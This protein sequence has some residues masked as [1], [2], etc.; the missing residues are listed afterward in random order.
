MQSTHHQQTCNIFK[1]SAEERVVALI[2]SNLKLKGSDNVCTQRFTSRPS[3][4]PRAWTHDGCPQLFNRSGT[5]SKTY[6]EARGVKRDAA[7]KQHVFTQL[8]LH[9]QK[10]QGTM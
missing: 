2:Y 8:V 4:P 5:A 9:P 7:V 3:T 1:H 10:N 6:P